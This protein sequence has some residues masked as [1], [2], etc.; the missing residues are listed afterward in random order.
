MRHVRHVRHAAL[1]NPHPPGDDWPG[2]K[3]VHLAVE[4]RTRA[5]VRAGKKAAGNI[6]RTAGRKKAHLLIDALYYNKIKIIEAGSWWLGSAVGS[7]AAAC[8]PNAEPRRVML[9]PTGFCVQAHL[10]GRDRAAQQLCQV[11]F[12]GRFSRPK[13]QT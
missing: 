3:Q 10:G 8:G 5:G 11:L 6:V 1:T 12:G 4:C 13:N 2:Y 9:G 7:S